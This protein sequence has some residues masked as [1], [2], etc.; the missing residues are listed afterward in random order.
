MNKI[1]VVVGAGI[2][3]SCSQS[4]PGGGSSSGAVS[5]VLANASATSAQ[6]RVAG[7]RNRIGTTASTACA[8]RDNDA[9]GAPTTHESGFCFTPINI[10]G[11]VTTLNLGSTTATGSGGVRLLGGGSETG[12]AGAFGFRKFD[13]LSADP[14]EGE[15]NIQD[16]AGTYNSATLSYFHLE[17]VF[18]AAAKTWHVRYY[19][20]NSTPSVESPFLGCDVGASELALLDETA[21]TLSG[22]VPFRKYDVMACIETDTETCADDADFK[23]IDMDDVVDE[24][25]LTADDYSL[26]STRPTNPLRLKNLADGTPTTLFGGD[27]ACSTGTD[28]PEYTFSNVGF[29]FNITNTLTELSA[30]ISGGSKTYSYGGTTGNKL[31]ATL[32]FDLENFMFYPTISDIGSD[33]STTGDAREAY[34]RSTLNMIVPKTLQILKNRASRD[35]T[36]TFPHDVAITLEVSTDE[37]LNSSSESESES[38]SG[39]GSGSGSGGGSSLIKN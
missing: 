33:L 35:T 3:S 34:L 8:V 24:N 14:F 31:T 36:W 20:F 21:A 10:L 16:S 12:I 32:N 2:L 11:S 19:F 26:V 23:W 29:T 6:S 13:L 27:D 17:S 25:S 28:H 9:N 4:Q 1:Y 37:S 7:S 30:S 18:L 38:G 5:I 39:E 22:S 15:D